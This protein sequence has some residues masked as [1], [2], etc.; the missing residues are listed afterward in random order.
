MFIVL[1]LHFCHELQL[2]GMVVLNT[3]HPATAKTFDPERHAVQL[4]NKCP[5]F[6]RR[7]ITLLQMQIVINNIINIFLQSMKNCTVNMGLWCDGVK[8]RK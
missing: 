3:T 8:S 1:F 5:C 4:V 2:S 7:A 6:P